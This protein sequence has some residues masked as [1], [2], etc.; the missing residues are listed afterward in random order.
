MSKWKVVVTDWEFESLNYELEI[1]E[2]EQVEV[3]PVQCK[4]E[5]EVIAHC[6]DADAIINQYAP[7]S[8]SVIESLQN[9]KVIARYGVGVN[10]IAVDAATDKGICVTNVPDYCMDEVSDHTLGL[11]LSWARKI[12]LADKETKDNHWDFKKTRPI[13]RLRGRTLGLLGFG[14]IPQALAEK[15][16]PLGLSV[17]ACD[18]YFSEEEAEK[19]GVELVSLEELCQG[20]DIISVHAPLTD[21]TKGLLSEAEFKRMKK[22][23]FVI[24]TSR[25]P[26]IDEASLISALENNHIAGAALDVVETEPIGRDHP[27]LAMENVI[28]TPHMAWYSEEAEKEMR[29]KVAMGVAD[30][31]LHEQYPKYLVNEKVKGKLSLHPNDSERRYE[32]LSNS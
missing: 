3:I 7:I 11:L 28:L 25:G 15:V 19:K 32:L 27:F 30:V 31:L 14:K 24:N 29:S 1:L 18:P 8:R 10:T 21:S 6:R 5:S 12:P 4:S 17:L 20:S 13:H 9:C 22:H 26:V 16:K 2:H 23:A